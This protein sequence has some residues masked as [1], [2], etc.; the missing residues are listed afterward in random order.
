M[1]FDD[2]L[3]QVTTTGDVS[4]GMVIRSLLITAAFAVFIFF[5]YRLVTRKS[6]YSKTFNIALAI[7]PVITASVVITIQSSLVVSL[8]MVGALSIVRFRNAVKDSLDLVFLFWSI[9]T[10]IICG[11][12]LYGI[13][14]IMSAVAALGIVLL[15]LIPVAKAPMLLIVHAEDRTVRETVLKEVT[16]H[17]SSYSVKSQTVQNGKL[18]LIVEIRIGKERGGELIDRVCVIPG[19]TRCSLVNYNGEVTF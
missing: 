13:A 10:G 4:S 8:G 12:Q 1:T 15:N 18:N 14:A 6:F 19:V 7:L 17:A 2:F 9:S 16:A 5:F 3:K 11:A